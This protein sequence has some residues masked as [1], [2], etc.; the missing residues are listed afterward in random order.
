M[1]TTTTPEP[2]PS[3]G[4]DTLS[5][6]PGRPVPHI[7]GVDPGK[8]GAIGAVGLDGNVLFVCGCPTVG[9]SDEP[10]VAAMAGIVR[11]LIGRG[12]VA[13]YLEDV[14]RQVFL[15]PRPGEKEG[16]R[17]GATVLRESWA[18]WRAIAVTLG[19]PVRLVTPAAWQRQMYAGT[20]RG[21]K[22]E[23]RAIMAARA[24][25]GP[26]INLLRSQRS[27]KDCPDFAVALLL[28]EFGRRERRS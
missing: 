12:A 9:T 20:P 6:L 4:T 26:G 23:T 1:T 10:D 17:A 18:T 27:R 24:I 14:A 5:I 8:R 19:L 2:V 15:P 16:R 25:W 28:A 21:E 11:D 13:L 3:I 7:L 22:S